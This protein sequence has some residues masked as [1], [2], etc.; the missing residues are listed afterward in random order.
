M[1]IVTINSL[2][3]IITSITEMIVVTTITTS[4]QTTTMTKIATVLVPKRW[5]VAVVCVT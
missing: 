5:H 3:T 1:V 2:A 4:A